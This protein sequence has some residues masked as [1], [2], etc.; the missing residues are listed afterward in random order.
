[1]WKLLQL[2][3]V[4]A[5]FAS[6]I[7]WQWS[8]GGYATAFVATGVAIIVTLTFSKIIDLIR[9]TRLNKRTG[10]RIEYEHTRQG[11]DVLRRPKNLI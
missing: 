8:S 1:M 10:T 6:D 5:V 2:S 9:G 4:F 11:L 7:H 3:V